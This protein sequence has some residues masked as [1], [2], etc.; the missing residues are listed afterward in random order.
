[1]KEKNELAKL[2]LAGLLIA[3]HLPADTQAEPV[4]ATGV[5]LAVA[6][7]PAHGCPSTHPSK[8]NKQIADAAG[9]YARPDNSQGGSYGIP[10]SSSYNVGGSYGGVYNSTT[11]AG[12]YSATPSINQGANVGGG[13]GV[14]ENRPG[15][16]SDA[17]AWSGTQRSDLGTSRVQGYNYNAYNTN[18]NFETSPT[19]QGNYLDSS[20]YS[21]SVAPYG[22]PRTT[23]GNGQEGDQVRGYGYEGVATAGI[24]T[25]PQLISQLT[26]QG[27]NLYLNLDP[28]GKALALQLASQANF[29]NKDLAVREAAKRIQERRSYMQNQMRR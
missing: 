7:C 23:F 21:E 18:R 16:A 11:N 24:M 14:P 20:Y 9:D 17:G 2:A 6:G 3:A 26:P 13:Y 1:M 22:A 12:S 8:Q 19:Y 5:L 28:E 25:E 15:S 10:S 4:N 29:S 27:R